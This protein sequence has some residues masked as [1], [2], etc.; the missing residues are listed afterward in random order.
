MI[1]LGVPSTHVSMQMSM[2]QNHHVGQTPLGEAAGAH[3]LSAFSVWGTTPVQKSLYLGCL[4]GW[5]CWFSAPLTTLSLSLQSTCSPHPQP[6]QLPLPSSMH[7]S[8]T[9]TLYFVLLPV[10]TTSFSLND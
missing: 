10:G 3:H 1:S 9:A 2:S 7:Q 4:D 8:S 6:P 5:L